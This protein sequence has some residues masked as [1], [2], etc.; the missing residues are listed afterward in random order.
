VGDA[1]VVASVICEAGVL[2][3]IHNEKHKNNTTKIHER[4]ATLLKGR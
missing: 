4:H 3:G 2:Y 1:G